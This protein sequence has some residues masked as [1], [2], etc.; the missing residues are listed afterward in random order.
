MSNLK[1]RTMIDRPHDVKNYIKDTPVK[2]A[3]GSLKGCAGKISGCTSYGGY[4]VWRDRSNRET[5]SVYCPIGPIGPF[6][7]NELELLN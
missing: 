1:R 6:L 7:Q 2:I 4:F 3:K 5:N